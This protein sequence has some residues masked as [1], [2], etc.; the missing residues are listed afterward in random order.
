LRIEQVVRGLERRAGRGELLDVGCGD[1]RIGRRFA[2]LG[3]RVSGVDVSAEAVEAARA[4]GIDAGVGDAS[5]PLRYP[6][7]RF[8]V[9]YAGEI[10]EHLFDTTRF[11]AEL[12][13]VT[14]PGGACVVT[15]PN[16][17][18]LPDRLRFLLGR[19][20]AQTQPLHPFLRLHI[21][22]FTKGTLCEAMG[23]AGFQVEAVESTLVVLSR[24]R[25]DPDRVRFA[26]RAPARWFPALGSFLIAFAV[27]R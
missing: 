20:P 23:A 11:L 18:H 5:E 2:E 19:A 9:V 26:L 13:R 6:D 24:Q 25:D 16:L 17:A 21:R 3:F 4:A 27:R 12:H 10:I 15:T 22:P 7:A 1:G 8:D 14:K